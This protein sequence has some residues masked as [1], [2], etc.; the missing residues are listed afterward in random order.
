MFFTFRLALEKSF[1]GNPNM[2]E[3]KTSQATHF[4]Q[5]PLRESPAWGGL[6]YIL[7]QVTH[8]KHSALWVKP[9]WGVLN[10]A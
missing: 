10:D 6:I 5:S 1:F 7:P 9:T 2:L 3:L 4:K 8:F